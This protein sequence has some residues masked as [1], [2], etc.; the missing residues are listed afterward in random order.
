MRLDMS[1]HQVETARVAAAKARVWVFPDFE[2]H[3]I[4]ITYRH[5]RQLNELARRLASL[6]GP[7][8]PE[9]ELPP[10]VSSEG[11]DPVIAR[12]VEGQAVIDWL[13]ARIVEIERFTHKLPSVGVL[14]NNEDEVRP[15]TE[16]LDAALSRQNI[17]CSSGRFVGQEND[18]RVFDV[19]HIKG[20][21][22]EAVFFVGI[23]E[24]AAR[25]S[26]L[27][28]KFLYVGAT[29]AATYLGITCS[30]PNLPALIAPLESAFAAAWA[31]QGLRGHQ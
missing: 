23:D 20:L 14:V 15:V 27:F 4:H 1:L 28:D 24:L 6:S 16:A 31:D 7:K 21:E 29:R 11:V 12:G 26:D 9:A 22:F 10:Y 8:A 25:H 17:A 2:V 5:S 19:Q 3:P 30:G 18:V 13:S